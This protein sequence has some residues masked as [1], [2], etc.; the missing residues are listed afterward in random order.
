[1]SDDPDFGED[2]SFEESVPVPASPPPAKVNGS[3]AVFDEESA[4][5]QLLRGVLGSGDSTAFLSLP[6][7]ALNLPQSIRIQSALRAGVAWD[8]AGAMIKAARLPL[9]D[10]VT[11]SSG[12][13]TS[14]LIGLHAAELRRKWLAKRREELLQDALK[15]PAIDIDSLVK[16]LAELTA[17]QAVKREVR[18]I[19]SFA[20]PS[21]D[22]PNVLLGNDDYLGRGGGFLFVSHAGAG[23]SSWAMQACMSWA[24]GRPWLGIRCNGPLKTLII[25]AE[26]SDRYIGKIQASFAHVNKLTPQEVTQVARNC[27]IVRLKGVSGAAFFAELRRLVEREKPDLVVINPIYLYAE[28]DIGRSEFAQPFL[29]G[30][31][32]INKDEKFAY[33]LIHHTGKPQAKGTNGKRAEVE[34]WESVYMG[35]GSSYLANWPRCSALLEPKA[36][37]AGKYSLKL[38]K[39]GLNA[40]I[41][42]EVE[43][44]AGKRLEPVTRINLCHSTERME[45]GGRDRP[46]YYWESYEEDPAK[47]EAQKRGGRPKAGEFN[48]YALCFPVGLAKALP[49]A[50][51]RRACISK[52]SVARPTFDRYIDEWV[53]EGNVRRDDSVF[54]I[55]KYYLP[56]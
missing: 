20:Y 43:Q 40:G 23:K 50:E 24:L 2:V 26:D 32:A 48:D 5:V 30:L 44:G 33:I 22:D 15:N 10:Y 13:V 9:A 41:V 49:L 36:G 27:V 31:D 55:P 7:A 53:R 16:S 18:P 37:Q 19:T 21:A 35:F 17:E 54:G 3:H 1:M 11:L 46:V 47:A 28:G 6:A 39:G 52:K 29:V 12:F 42:R 56:I 51:V 38:G 14:A 25:Q 4:E 45:V 8:D 34:D